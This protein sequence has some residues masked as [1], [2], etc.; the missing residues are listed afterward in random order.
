LGQFHII[1]QAVAV[2]IASGAVVAGIAERIQ[3]IGHLPAIRE[4]VVVGIRV[5]GIRP[6]GVHFRAIVQAVAIGV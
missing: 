4:G 1:G 3:A 5:E 2:R 6:V